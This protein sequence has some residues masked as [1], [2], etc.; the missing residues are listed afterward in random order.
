MKTGQQ[1]YVEHVKLN[2][3]KSFQLSVAKCCLN[4]MLHSTIWQCDFLRDILDSGG[5]KCLEAL[6]LNIAKRLS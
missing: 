5:Q 4:V 3:S 2:K 6:S 1:I